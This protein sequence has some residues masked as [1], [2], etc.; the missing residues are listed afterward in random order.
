MKNY[1]AIKR[2]L[3]INQTYTCPVCNGFLGDYVGG[4][5]DLHHKMRNTKGNR[6]RYPKLI[7]NILNLELVHH[8]CHIDHHGSCG[9]MADIEA[10]K[11]ERW[12]E[13]NQDAKC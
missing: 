13:E 11:F 10:E 8:S 4:P 5:L 6:K 9:K 12:L 2:Q 3:A 1:E 7:D